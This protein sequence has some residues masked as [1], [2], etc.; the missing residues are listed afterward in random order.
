M[1][2]KACT[3]EQFS[4]LSSVLLLKLSAVPFPLAPW[5]ALAEVQL[6][7]PA[8]FVALQCTCCSAAWKPFL[9]FYTAGFQDFHDVFP[10]FL[11]C[12]L[13]LIADQLCFA[14]VP[15]NCTFHV[16]LYS[17]VIRLLWSIASL[18]WAG[19]CRVLL[20]ILGAEQNCSHVV[21][22]HYFLK[23]WMRSIQEKVEAHVCAYDCMYMWKTQIKLREMCLP[24]RHLSLFCKLL[25]SYKWVIIFFEW[26]LKSKIFQKYSKTI[27]IHAVYLPSGQIPQHCPKMTQWYI[28]GSV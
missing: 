3:P 7:G 21:N 12:W 11:I 15:L 24:W 27:I 13:L 16:R 4:D 26:S 8:V 14:D 28:C 10:T 18:P 25:P 5:A 6:S 23:E 20:W 2:S 19:M 22:V 17:S 1:K 9:L